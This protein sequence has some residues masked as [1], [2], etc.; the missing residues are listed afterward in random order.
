MAFSTQ[1]REMTVLW[2]H[3]VP[4]H[5]SSPSHPC[6]RHG[7]QPARWV[8]KGHHGAGAQ[9]MCQQGPWRPPS[10]ANAPCP[11]WSS[12]VTE[13]SFHSKG[14]WWRR[15]WVGSL[16][17]QLSQGTAS[18]SPGY[19]VSVGFRFPLNWKGQCCAWTCVPTSSQGTGHLRLL[20][21]LRAQQRTLPY[22]SGDA[23]LLGRCGCH[24]FFP[25]DPGKT[26]AQLQL[27][28]VA[29][30]CVVPFSVISL[31]C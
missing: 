3:F 25:G 10:L 19:L 7:P 13:H 14:R 17:S 15:N 6:P 11:G 27:A 12:V 1:F 30:E 31:V 16:S 8:Y 24:L 9:P 4:R 5:L 20:F 18:G 2:P 28:E 26:A 21:L 22:Q 29:L 23:D